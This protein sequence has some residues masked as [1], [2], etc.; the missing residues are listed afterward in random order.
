MQIF[1]DGSWELTVCHCPLQRSSIE[2]EHVPAVLVAALFV[3]ALHAEETC[4]PIWS[5]EKAGQRGHPKENS[6]L[7]LCISDVHCSRYLLEEK[8]VKRLQISTLIEAYVKFSFF[9]KHHSLRHINSY[10]KPPLL[11]CLYRSY[12][13]VYVKK[14]TGHV[15]P[16]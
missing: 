15:E 11:S 8:Y 6:L 10:L 3:T 2:R 5:A 12:L 4:V 16:L 1:S 14:N 13:I 9:L 7:F